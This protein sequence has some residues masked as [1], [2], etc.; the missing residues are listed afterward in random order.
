MITSIF[1][2]LNALNYCES[3]RGL[4]FC[5]HFW[6]GPSDMSFH[7]V[8]GVNI[9][10]LYGVFS[11]WQRPDAVSLSC[12]VISWV[13]S[14][15]LL[16]NVSICALKKKLCEKKKT[17]QK[18]CFYAPRRK[19]EPI[20]SAV[21]MAKSHYSFK[22]LHTRFTKRRCWLLSQLESGDPSAHIRFW[23][24]CPIF[25]TWYFLKRFMW[26]ILFAL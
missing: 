13:S 12:C 15:L 14:H 5:D 19:K 24:Y 20:S 26:D 22:V 3:C 7:W 8:M 9:P 25:D 1:L 11:C 6:L 2:S 23:Q 21:N 17:L 18:Y 4:S 10:C 16:C